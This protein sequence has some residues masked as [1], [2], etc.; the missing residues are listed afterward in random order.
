MTVREGTVDSGGVKLHYL[1][2]G[3]DG[4]PLILLHATGF[5]ARLWQP[6]AE[7]LTERFRIV[8]YDQR[9]HGDSDNPPDGYTFEQ[10]ADDLDAVIRGLE[11]DRA[12]GARD[13]ASIVAAGHSSG[14]STIAVHAAHYPGVITRATLIEPILPHKNMWRN[15]PANANERAEQARKRRA[16]W[17]STNEMFESFRSRSPFDTWREDVLRI[18]IEEGTRARPDGQVELKCPPHLEA[19]YYE[20]VREADFMPLLAKVQIPLLLVWGQHNELQKRMGYAISQALKYAVSFTMPGTTHFP[21]QEQ[22][23]EIA[24]LLKRDSIF[25]PSLA[26]ASSS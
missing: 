1:D 6:I 12:G 15:A 3:G 26:Q 10:F 19:K 20:A 25:I 17:T 23:D 16:V 24:E 13:A 9:G 5:L 22:P 4:P 18:Y 21:P 8:A 7:Q 11:L 14:A 2:W